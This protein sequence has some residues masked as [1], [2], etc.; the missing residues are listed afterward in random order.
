MG[1]FNIFKE[2][3]IQ[4][5][6]SAIVE[7]TVPE[8]E[9][10]YYKPDSYYTMASYPGTEFE[11]K[12]ITF[13]ERKKT[14]IPSKRGL[15]PAEILLL[16][17][18]TY[19]NYPGPK[20][21]YPG[22]WWFEYGIRDVGAAL[23]SLESRGF[24]ALGSPC[25]SLS[26]LTLAELK[27]ILTS[28]GYEA[29]GKKTDLIASISEKVTDADLI[30]MGLQQKYHLTELGEEELKENA[31]VPYMNKTPLKT[32]EDYRFGKTFNVWSVN[33]LL[34]K[35]D[36]SNWQQI[37]NSLELDLQ[38]EYKAKHNAEMQKIKKIDP[39]G[40]EKLKAQDDQIEK[41]NNRK[42]KFEEDSDI[43]SYI[44]FWEKLW[45]AG[46]LLFGSNSWY[47]ELP[48]LYIKVKRYDDALAFVQNLKK[49]NPSY[50]EKCD[51]YI[52]KINKH[53]N[54]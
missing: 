49:T 11:S 5:S 46:G 19:G 27:Q 36:K 32:S 26:G 10:K 14:A 8:E 9:K 29:K 28:K 22:L 1:L 52:E 38:K 48:D 4:K 12:V 33:K 30:G 42:K 35:G 21:G 45:A 3:E 25:E 31:Y 18:C 17:H 39:K 2:K 53:I 13:D 40:Y 50:T 16:E 34:G 54:K 41:V 6:G 47:F 20:N 37:V 43:E 7:S 23:R 15:Y 51:K 24:I 44:T